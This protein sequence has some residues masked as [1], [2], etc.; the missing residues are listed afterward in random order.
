MSV[1][2]LCY[3]Q[4]ARPSLILFILVYLVFIFFNLDM[5]GESTKKP[6]EDQ[7]E[8]SIVNNTQ[9]EEKA[10]MFERPEDTA[11]VIQEFEF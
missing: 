5:S 4:T 6:P 11:K 10:K 2:L 8:E 9:I 3:P 7:K 1:N